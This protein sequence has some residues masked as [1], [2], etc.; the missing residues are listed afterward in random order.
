MKDC[1]N[2][3]QSKPHSSHNPDNIIKNP[4]I[5]ITIIFFNFTKI[6]V[7]TSMLYHAFLMTEF[8]FHVY[9]NVNTIFLFQILCLKANI[10]F[11]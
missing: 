9:V 2:A 6:K 10:S 11:F 7:K 3:K 4:I 8:C 5:I 1:N